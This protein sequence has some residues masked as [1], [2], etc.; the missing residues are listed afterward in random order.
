MAQP[1]DDQGRAQVTADKVQTDST[2]DN[3]ATLAQLR[4]LA[5]VFEATRQERFRASFLEGLDFLFDAQYANGGWPQFYPL[6][7]DY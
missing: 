6:R 4:Y 1:L 5:R 3:G 7:D 2:I